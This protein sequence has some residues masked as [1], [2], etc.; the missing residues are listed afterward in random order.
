M[1]RCI[2]LAEVGL[3]TTYPNPLVGAVVVYYDKIIGEG[4]HRQSGQPHAE[5]LAIEQVKDK[6]IL[7]QCTLYVNLEPCNHHGK[8]PPCTEFII[9]SGIKTVYVGQNDPNPLVNGKGIEML[10]KNGIEVHQGILEQECKCL[11]IR[12]NTYHTQLRPYIVLKW[13]QSPGGYISKHDTVKMQISNTYSNI[14][15]HKWRSQEQSVMVGYNTALADNPQLNVRH[16]TGNQPTRVVI[17]YDL[18]L[19][20]HLH[21]FDQSVPTIIINK[22]KNETKGYIIYSQIDTFTDI[23][24]RL[25]EHKIISVLVEGGAKI[26]NQFINNN[27]WD[28]ARVIVGNVAIHSG[29]E[30]PIIHYQ[31]THKKDIMGDLLYIYQNQYK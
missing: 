17:D 31:Y 12:F 3:G 23:V 13:A 22:I 9:K 24:Q 20:A 7:A 16:W 11:N 2:Q 8:T 14:Y 10:Q 26:L 27:I 15:V 6:S 18:S 21:V 19:P 30:A 28:E 29:I 4:Y 1:R 5:V 25:Y